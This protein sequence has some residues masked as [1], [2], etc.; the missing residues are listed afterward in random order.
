VHFG[1]LRSAEE[2][3]ERAGLAQVW[4]I[5]ASSPPHKDAHDIAP[6]AD[7][8]RMLEL[9]LGDDAQLRPCG[10]ELERSGPS[11]TID[12]L[13]LLAARHPERRF[14]LVLGLD[15]FRELHTWH[16]FTE[17]PAACDLVVTSRPPEAV[18]AGPDALAHATDSIAVREAFRYVPDIR[19]F[20]HSS[21]NRLEFVPVTAIDISASAIRA[22]VAA[23]RSIRFLTPE[24]VVAYIRARGLY[25]PAET[26]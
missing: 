15:A 21:G 4:L 10:I 7:R 1:H 5:P 22:A 8:L 6:A 18:E 23:G 12:T 24:P 19:S 3:R 17:L 26:A 20:R 13:H 25:G 11:Y 14:A 2:V 9:A 16:R